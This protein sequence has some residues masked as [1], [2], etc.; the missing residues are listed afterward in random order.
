MKYEHTLS[1]FFLWYT[2]HPIIVAVHPSLAS[3]SG[4]IFTVTIPSTCSDDNSIVDLGGKYT[5]A[6]TPQCRERDE[7]LVN[8][9]VSPCSRFMSSLDDDGKVILDVDASYVDDC[10]ANL[11]E[12]TFDGKLS[13][14][15]DESLSLEAGDDADPFTIGQDTIYGKVSV[16]VPDD[17]SGEEYEFVDVSVESVYVCTTPEAQIS[18]D[19]YSGRGGCLSSTIDADGPYTVIGSGADTKYEGN[20]F[21]AVESNEAAFSFLA[22]GMF[23]VQY[24]C[25]LSSIPSL[26]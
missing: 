16:N 3:I 25:S 12:I 20:T 8:A 14:Y 5:F 2:S 22:F 9:A 4:Q 23:S 24:R 13:F 6:F 10:N 26:V 7:G 18:V 11:F 1:L 21:D 17:P 19:S 15:R